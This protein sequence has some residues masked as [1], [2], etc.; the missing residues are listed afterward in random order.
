M[1]DI[2]SRI[3]LSVLF[4]LAGVSPCVAL[5]ANVTESGVMKIKADSIGYDA[6]SDSYTATGKVRIDWSGA[7]MFADT[8]SLL[9]K[10]TLAN[11]EGNILVK[12]DENT[13]HGDNASF[14][15]ETGKGEITNGRLFVQQGNFR[16]S[17]KKLLKTGPED[18]RIENGSFTTC[19]GDVPS[20]KFSA[21]ELDVTREEYAVGRHA[22]FYIKD[23]PLLYLP[24]IVYPV[25]ESR[26]SGFL[27][28]RIGHSTKKGFYLELPYYLVV[29]PSQEATFYLDVMTNRG[30]GA[31]A[32]YK[33]IMRSG[34]HGELNAYLLYDTE[35]NMTRG[36][37][38]AQHQ[39]SFSPTLFFS[40]DISLT[41]DRDFY[42]DFGEVSGE[43][44]KQYLESIAFL[45]KQWER[46]SLTTELRY[47]E[48]LYAKNNSLTLQKLPVITFT[49]I[50]QRVGATPFFVSLDSSF[51]DFF[52]ENGLKGQRLDL[53]PMLTY[54][55]SPGGVL[56]GSVW[57]GYRHRLY[58][59]YGGETSSGFTNTGMPDVG[60][61]VSTTLSRVYETGW[62][63]LKKIKHT[64]IPEIT[65][66][67]RP[68]KNQ[69]D[70]P[71][72]DYND[73]LVA[74]NMVS[75]SFTN[76]LT[77][78][79]LS[80]DN[81]ATYRDLAYLRISQGYEFSGARRD[82]LTLVDEG[83]PFTDIRLET[84]VYPTERTSL[85]IDS[86]FNPYH[87]HFST[88]AVATDVADG[89]G[90]RV[91]VGYRFAQDQVRYLEGKLDLNYLNPFVFHYLTR[92]SFDTRDFIESYYSLEVKQKCWGVTFTY[93]ER[94][95]DHGFMI[96]F[97]LSGLGSIGKFK[98]F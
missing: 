11:A 29:S 52:R 8:V 46:F 60:A 35:E 68:Q 79:Y 2:P 88:F 50:K 19:D 75:Y 17:G 30:A 45:T 92:Y 22:V 55:T 36:T 28:P 77:G 74:Q 96:S 32:D 53:H 83:K 49:G 18:Y 91:G 5:E 66:A 67:Y 24:Y 9:Q 97:T 15:L 47:T 34:G 33:Y 6:R 14:N 27:L 71:F 76:Y 94:P 61:A 21:A 54:Y 63:N 93:R 10:G 25:K 85:S 86:R 87:M 95:G 48:D 84:K 80:G 1:R 40:A 42:R 78:K 4:L 73:R 81:P 98:A 31:G 3:L 82:V 39:Q 64:L 89:K 57:V 13:I 16:V 72:F 62:G 43:Y 26:Q 51:T 12:Q 44:N 20:W 58:N 65:Y 41:L 59:T 7:T 56:E 38:L 69:D 90:N 23:I 37:L 70:L